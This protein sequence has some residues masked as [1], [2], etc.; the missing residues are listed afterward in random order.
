MIFGAAAEYRFED[1]SIVS[2]NQATPAYGPAY[3]PP[4]YI[5]PVKVVYVAGAAPPPLGPQPERKYIPQCERPAK[6]PPR[7]S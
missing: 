7:W 5:P 3:P 2:L 6:W 4:P 1:D